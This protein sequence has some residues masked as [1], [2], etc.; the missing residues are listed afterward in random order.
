[1][2]MS[3][4][5]TSSRLLQACSLLFLL[6]F[7]NVAHGQGKTIIKEKKLQIPSW[8]A[9]MDDPNANYFEAIKAFD[10][11]WK[12]KEKPVEEDESFESVGDKKKEEALRERAAK[13][14]ENAPTVKYAFEYKRFLHW[15]AEIEPFVQS[16]GRIKSM[17]ERTGEWK[18]QQQQKQEQELRVRTQPPN[19]IKKN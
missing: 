18:K 6:M 1:M 3:I 15:K 10:S 13:M 2:R 4:P 16:D 19:K 12:H 5:F 9:M 11:Y 7:M 17:D 8:I 14:N